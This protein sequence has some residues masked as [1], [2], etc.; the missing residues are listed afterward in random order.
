MKNIWLLT[1]LDGEVVIHKHAK[2]GVDVMDVC[3]I[4]ENE[5]NDGYEDY[6]RVTVDGEVYM[7]LEA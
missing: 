5:V 4:A 6:A 7:E 2:A 3:E 1:M